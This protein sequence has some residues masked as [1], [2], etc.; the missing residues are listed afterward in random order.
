MAVACALSSRWST[1]EDLIRA[2]HGRFK[3]PEHAAKEIWIGA[4][5]GI[6]PFISW[7]K[8]LNNNHSEKAQLS[9]F[10]VLIPTKHSPQLSAFK[11]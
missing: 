11:N 2:P 5:V 1:I 3:R 7:L 10:I 9:L 4:G 8:D 6:T